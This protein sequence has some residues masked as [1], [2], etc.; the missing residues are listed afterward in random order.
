MKTA[1]ILALPTLLLLTLCTDALAVKVHVDL[2]AANLKQEGFT[3]QAV[4]REDGMIDVTVT[5]DL[6]KARSFDAASDLELVRTATLEVQGPEGLV[7]RCNLECQSVENAV[8]YRL[9]IAG[10]NLADSRLTISEIDDYKKRENREHLIGGG[11]HFTIRLG[12]V[13]KP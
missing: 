8:V 2:T 4:K 11:T 10:K 13:V 3:V 7:V 5:R 6:S 9:Q 12:D 1:S